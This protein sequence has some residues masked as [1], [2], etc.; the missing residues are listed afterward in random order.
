MAAK[1]PATLV[2]TLEHPAAYL[3][4]LLANWTAYP[5]PRHAMT[6]RA[7]WMRPGNYVANGPF[8]LAAWLP[9]DHITLKKNPRFYDAAHVRLDT[10]NYYPTSDSEAALRAACKVQSSECK[11]QSKRS[12]SVLRA[13]KNCSECREKM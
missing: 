5:L 10:V 4:E 6:R 8:V 9:N 3:P 7:D 1:D 12:P 11:V 2:V 13:R